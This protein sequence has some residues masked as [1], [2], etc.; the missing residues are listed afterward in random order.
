LRVYCASKSRHWPW[1]AAL[2]A[3]GID[4]RSSWINWPHNLDCT[5]PTSV[6]WRE[7]W[8]GCI[9]EATEADVILVFAQVDE[10]QNGALIELGAGLASGAMVYLFSDSAWSVSHHPRVRNFRTLADAITAIVAADAGERA[11]ARA[12]A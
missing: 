9:V 8:K 12:A 4:I 11:R 2:R 6:E 5:E 3:A 7:N 10:R 1:W